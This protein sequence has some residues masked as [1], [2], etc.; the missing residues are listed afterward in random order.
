MVIAIACYSCW[1]LCITKLSTQFLAPNISR[2]LNEKRRTVPQQGSVESVGHLP[3]QP[4]RTAVQTWH[5]IMLPWLLWR[6]RPCAKLGCL[7]EFVRRVAGLDWLYD[8]DQS[9]FRAGILKI[10]HVKAAQGAFSDT[11][12]ISN[13]NDDSIRAVPLLNSECQFCLWRL[14]WIDATNVGVVFNSALKHETLQLIIRIT[15]KCLLRWLWRHI[16]GE[17]C[18]LEEGRTVSG[19]PSCDA[20]HTLK[21]DFL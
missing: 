15:S 16:N 3:G 1:L 17:G 5:R 18:C 11:F 12:Y 13:V 21:N 4:C 20:T 19:R 10:G 2:P 8:N 7:C 9:R 6:I 14:A